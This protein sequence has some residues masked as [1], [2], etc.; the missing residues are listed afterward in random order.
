[1]SNVTVQSLLFRYIVMIVTI[2]V[3]LSGMFPASSA[4]ALYTM[5]YV[6]AVAVS[7]PEAFKDKIPLYAGSLSVT[8]AISSV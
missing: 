7:T 1:M 5:V 8:F 6:P 4:L 3:T 2:R